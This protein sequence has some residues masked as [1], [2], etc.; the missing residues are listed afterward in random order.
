MSK[1]EQKT[2]ERLAIADSCGTPQYLQGQEK[3]WGDVKKSKL[4]DNSDS[5]NQKAFDRL[6][7]LLSE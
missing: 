5:V 4:P 6:D 2:I 7:I 1:R 3:W